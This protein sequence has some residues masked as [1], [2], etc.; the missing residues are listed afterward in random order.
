M[1]LVQIVSLTVLTAASAAGAT[2]MKA[3]ARAQ[4]NMTCPGVC[5]SQ[6]PSNCP[7]ETAPYE[8]SPIC[9][10]CCSG[11]SLRS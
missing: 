7:T 11:D 6:P 3:A 2:V 1:K 9:W 10:M 5:S 4:E 8:W